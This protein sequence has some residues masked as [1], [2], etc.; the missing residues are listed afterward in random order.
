MKKFLMLAGFAALFAAA[1]AC[2]FSSFK[3][4]PNPP[5]GTAGDSS[6]R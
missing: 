3:K 2:G 6:G 5:A 4:N 1:S